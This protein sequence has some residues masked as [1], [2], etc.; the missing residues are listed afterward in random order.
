MVLTQQKSPSGP[1]DLGVEGSQEQNGSKRAEEE[2]D[3]KADTKKVTLAIEEA[4]LEEDTYETR[5][6][7][8]YSRIASLGTIRNEH[9]GVG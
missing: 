9:A 6:R 1:A 4:D 3:A 8:S 5:H 2:E 7:V